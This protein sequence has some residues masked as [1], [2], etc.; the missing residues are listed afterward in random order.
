MDECRISGGGGFNRE[1]WIDQ[2]VHGK[3]KKVSGMICKTLAA[4]VTVD[5]NLFIDAGGKMKTCM[6]YIKLIFD[7]V[8]P[9]VFIFL[10]LKK[11]FLC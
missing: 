6:K 10:L 3:V 7:D 2:C 11:I 1:T 5:E 9:E 4:L 8:M